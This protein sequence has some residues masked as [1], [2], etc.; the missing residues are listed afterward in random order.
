MRG[1]GGHAPGSVPDI[2]STKRRARAMGDVVEICVLLLLLGG[3]LSFAEEPLDELE[4]AGA[5]MPEL[6][7]FHHFCAYKMDEGP[8]KA[9]TSRWYFNIETQKCE[10]FDYGGCRGNENN[11]ET[12]AIC[13][14]MCILRNKKDACKLDEDPGPCRGLITRYF[15]DV[16]RQQ[17]EKFLYG[18]CLGNGNNFRTLQDCWESCSNA[19]HIGT[20]PEHGTR[21]LSG[22]P[23]DTPKKM[24]LASDLNVP[25]FCQSPQEQGACTAAIK[26]WSFNAHAGRCHLFTY[27]GCGGNNNNFS[28]KKDCMR[29]CA[30]GDKNQGKIR[31]K[32]KNRKV[33]L[34]G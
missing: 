24:P 26:R 16:R 33:I 30:K 17:C 6:K 12:E 1:R 14:E 34:G 23:T 22:H 13:Q 29:V 2:P 27:S 20:I 4:G 19:S 10:P 25:N 5:S 28:T 3:T 8:C 11:F 31:I 9:L 15:Y 7:L 21:G 32:K 18:G